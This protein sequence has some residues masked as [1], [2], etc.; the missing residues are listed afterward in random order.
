MGAGALTFGK[1]GDGWAARVPRFEL[2]GSSRILFRV[3]PQS[4]C[5]VSRARGGRVERQQQLEV[6]DAASAGDAPRQVK[7]LAC[8]V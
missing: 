8:L 4:G 3:Q 7:G 5:G 1:H 6:D 2:A